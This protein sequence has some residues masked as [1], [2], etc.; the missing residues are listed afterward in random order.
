MWKVRKTTEQFITEANLVH[1]YK[2]DYELVDYKS[3]KIK[4]AVI[5]KTHGKFSVSPD[6]HLS[7][8]S[9]C[10]K[11]YH[12]SKKLNLINFIE[13]AKNIHG[14]KY[15]YSLVDLNL[16]KNKIIII[17]NIHGKFLQTPNSHLSNHGCPKCYG[18][19]KN[20]D[21]IIK[22]FKRTHGDKYDYSMIDYINSS[23]KVRI[24]CKKHGEFKQS[25]H[26]HIDGVGCPNC[27]L[28]KGEEKIRLFLKQNNIKFE[29]QKNFKKL[30]KYEFDFYLP[31][32]NILIE[33]DGKQHFE[34]VKIF[35]GKDEFIKT[36]YRDNVKDKFAE[37]NDI[38]LI[39][40]P[41]IKFNS[42]NEILINVIN[43]PASFSS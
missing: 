40:I 34:P 7:K 20:N 37:E 1:S 32:Q 38:K 25:I 27:N 26:H 15:D 33:Y 8:K 23:T 16:T 18:L 43:S 6:N 5:C 12:D 4:V 10:P 17:C 14:N 11:C 31:E 13:K 41:Y 9:G 29:Q 21:D 2:Y 39:R 3:N 36:I 30:G 24:V 22:L 19:Y 35:G 42:I 28:S